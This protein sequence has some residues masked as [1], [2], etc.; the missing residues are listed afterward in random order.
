MPRP[1]SDDKRSAIIAAATRIIVTH[2]LSA[3]TAGIAKEAGVANGS[4]FTYFETKADLF[5]ALYLELKLEMGAAIVRDLR[6]GDELRQQ[7]FRVWQNWMAWAVSFPEKR[8]ALAQ[9]G[10]S[11]EITPAT[12]TAADR[13]MANVAPLLERVRA[14]GPMRKSPMGLVL[15]LMNSVAESTLDFMAQDP[16][17]AKKHS[18]AGFDALW[19]M[20]A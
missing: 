6:G 9:L 19:R 12:R 13:G 1:R 17:N 15:T 8:R 4:L 20:V 16:A 11:D 10:V 18:R 3:P 7:L 2:G 5:N 14:S